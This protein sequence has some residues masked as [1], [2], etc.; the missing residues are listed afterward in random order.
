[1]HT[2]FPFVVAFFNLVVGGRAFSVGFVT[3]LSSSR[4]KNPEKISRWNNFSHRGFS[5]LALRSTMNYGFAVA[6]QNGAK[7]KKNV[8]KISKEKNWLI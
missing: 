7:R 4:K 5:E 8:A 2:H 6:E 3:L 1:M